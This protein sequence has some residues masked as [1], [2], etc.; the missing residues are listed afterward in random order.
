VVNN[1]RRVILSGMGKI[2]VAERSYLAEMLSGNKQFTTTG[3]ENARM[4]SENAA[5]MS[6]S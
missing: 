4:Y 2:G 6:P 1:C 5:V 3:T